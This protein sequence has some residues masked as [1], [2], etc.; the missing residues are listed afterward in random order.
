MHHIHIYTVPIPIITI[1]EIQ[2][3]D[4][5]NTV[6]DKCVSHQCALQAVYMHVA[7]TTKINPIN[8]IKQTSLHQQTHFGYRKYI[9]T[10]NRV[11]QTLSINFWLCS[12]DF[13]FLFCDWADGCWLDWF[14][15]FLLW[16]VKWKSIL[17]VLYMI[18]MLS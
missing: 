11:S 14:V 5:H 15:L 2:Q 8:S 6:F 12:L 7:S 4:G 18:K 9:D 10:C 13:F 16:S 3:Q 1:C 17:I